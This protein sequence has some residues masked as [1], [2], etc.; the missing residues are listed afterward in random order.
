MEIAQS[1]QSN[2]HDTSVTS[3]H[4]SKILDLFIQYACVYKKHP[5][6]GGN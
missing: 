6:Q 4:Q 5:V 3:G 2:K 1:F